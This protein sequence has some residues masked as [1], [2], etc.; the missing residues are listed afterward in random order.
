MPG[1]PITVTLGDE[2]TFYYFDVVGYLAECRSWG[3]HS[4]S[5]VLWTTPRIGRVIEGEGMKGPQQ[6]FLHTGLLGLVSGHFDIEQKAR[7]TGDWPAEI[8]TAI[9]SGIA[10][11][12][13]ASKIKDLIER[14]DVV[15]ARHSQI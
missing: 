1:D 14:E 10:V 6:P 2:Q 13:P 15:E 4:G 7:G 11:V 5:P 9:N 3:G 8:R 12:T